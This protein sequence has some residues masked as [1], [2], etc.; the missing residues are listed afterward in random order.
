MFVDARLLAETT[1]V[2]ADVC[3]IGAGPAGITLAR[4][5]IG[6]SLEVCLLESGGLELTRTRRHCVAARTSGSPTM[7]MTS[8]S[9]DDLAAH[10]MFGRALAGRSKKS[11]FGRVTASPTLDGRLTSLT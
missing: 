2:R 9:C 3:V 8:C 7:T 11:I 10:R 6:T 1:E 5:F 4:E